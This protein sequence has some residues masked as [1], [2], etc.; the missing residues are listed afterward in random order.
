MD[1]FTQLNLLLL[2]HTYDHVLLAGATCFRQ[3]LEPL[4]APVALMRD[5]HPPPFRLTLCALTFCALIHPIKAILGDYFDPDAAFHVNVK[6]S[7]AIITSDLNGAFNALLNH[8]LDRSYF[9]IEALKG[10][11]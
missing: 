10:H 5:I 7:V 3:V 9:E 2:N 11:E 8:A 6:V 1:S 4:L